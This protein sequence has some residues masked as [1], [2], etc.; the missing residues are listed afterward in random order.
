MHSAGRG[1]GG[2]ACV[3]QYTGWQGAALYGI[4]G[5]APSTPTMLEAGLSWRTLH[6]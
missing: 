3:R 4:G 5:A 1:G 6:G 2:A